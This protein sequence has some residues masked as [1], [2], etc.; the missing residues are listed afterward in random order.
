MKKY[1]LLLSLFAAFLLCGGV[2]GYIKAS[3]VASLIMSSIFSII[4]FICSFFASKNKLWGLY[5]AAVA[6]VFLNVFFLIRFLKSLAIFPAGAMT[7]AT[8]LVGIP[9]LSFLT[10][11]IREK[12]YS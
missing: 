1:S 10:Q 11:K 4:L 3:S 6:V 2:M 7:L 8:T 5:I 12:K 9:L